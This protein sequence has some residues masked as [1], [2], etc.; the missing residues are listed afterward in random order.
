ML[1][2]NCFPRF[3]HRFSPHIFPKII[4]YAIFVT[5]RGPQVSVNLGKLYAWYKVQWIA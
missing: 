3:E 4:I 1:L 2:F 5:C